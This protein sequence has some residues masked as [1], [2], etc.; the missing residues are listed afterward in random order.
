MNSMRISQILYGNENAS[1]L[2]ID[3]H[4]RNAT[5]GIINHRELGHS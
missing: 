2:A 4:N 5:G 3:R 1:D